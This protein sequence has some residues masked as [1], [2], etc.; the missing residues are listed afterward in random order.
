M[1]T[2]IIVDDEP[3]IIKGLLHNFSWEEQGFQI[4]DSF[5]NS[6]SALDFLKNSARVDV[7]LSDIYMPALNGLELARQAKAI[8]PN[9]TIVFISGFRDFEFARQAISLGVNEYL[10]KPLVYK[11]VY[12]TFQK[13][14]RNLDQAYGVAEALPAENTP[15]H[16][17]NKI[18]QAVIHYLKENVADASLEGAAASVG[19]SAG[20]LSKLYKMK[21]G[22]NFSDTL[23][24]IR[25]EKARELLDDVRLKTYEIADL[26]GYENPKNFSRAFKNY[27]NLSPSEYRNGKIIKL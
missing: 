22:K 9:I 4:V 24:K 16:M 10:T 6:F 1:Y 27:Y 26:V 18:I 8:H 14:K 15:P 21:T 13:I 17:C 25:M 7:L 12:E 20:Y 11:E 19:L 2:M 23:T 5:Q 3:K